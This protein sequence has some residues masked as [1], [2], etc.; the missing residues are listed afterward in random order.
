MGCYRELRFAASLTITNSANLALPGGTNIVTLAGDVLSF[1]CV[2][3]GQWVMVS[4]AP[5]IGRQ[6]GT[7][8]GT[9]ISGTTSGQLRVGGQTGGDTSTVFSF[10]G[11]MATA[12]GGAAG[13]FYTIFNAGNFDPATKANLASPT[14]TGNGNPGAP[15]GYAASVSGSFGGGYRMIDGATHLG[16][17]ASGGGM[18]WGVGTSTSLNN[19]MNMN[20]SGLL[21]PAGGVQ[22]P[23]SKITRVTVS[24]SAPG[25][26]ADGELYLRY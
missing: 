8:T 11:T 9:I 12:I 24:S 21:A 25:A 3:S 23:G 16:W 5:V 10:N 18:N 13:T 15:A 14:F 20:S 26:L 17:W 1:R 2:S 19:L 4:G 7:A 22:F 6:G